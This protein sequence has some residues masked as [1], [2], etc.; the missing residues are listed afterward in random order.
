MGGLKL[1]GKRTEAIREPNAVSALIFDLLQRS[2]VRTGRRE[3]KWKKQ[4]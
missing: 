4:Y 1:S 2:E 3:I